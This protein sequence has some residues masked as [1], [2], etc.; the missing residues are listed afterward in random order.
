VVRLSTKVEI[1]I[2][3]DIL[4][5]LMLIETVG[6]NAKK[7]KISNILEAEKPSFVLMV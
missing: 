1:E 3:I 2:I 7:P 4:N 5:G 6:C